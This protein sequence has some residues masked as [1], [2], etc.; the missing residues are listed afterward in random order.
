LEERER[1]EKIFAT[2][3]RVAGQFAV[4]LFVSGLVPRSKAARF[5]EPEHLFHFNVRVENCCDVW[6]PHPISEVAHCHTCRATFFSGNFG[7]VVDAWHHSLA[8][9]VALA[10]FSFALVM[11]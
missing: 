7:E 8:P 1:A 4:S 2:G 3:T 11:L 6:I 5:T 10:L 9:H